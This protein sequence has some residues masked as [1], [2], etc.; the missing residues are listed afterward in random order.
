[1]IRPLV[2]SIETPIQPLSRKY[3][4]QLPI[5]KVSVNPTRIV[6][7]LGAVA[8]ALVAVSTAAQLADNLTGYSSVFIHKLV[9]LLNVD[10]ELNVPTFFSSFILLVSSMLLGVIS[11]LKRMQRAPYVVHWAVLSAGFLF[12]AF[13]ETVSVHERLIEPVRPLLG[14]G[15]LGIWYFAWVVPAILLVL[16]LSLVFLRFVMNLPVRIR[17]WFLIAAALYLGAAI[18]FELFEG[19]HVEV[20]GKENLVYLTLATIEEGAEMAGVIIFIRA[21]LDYIGDTWAALHIRFDQLSTR[22][23]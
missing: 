9:K 2:N 19:S 17:Q 13:D 23:R 8:A 18:G 20:Y 6:M 21:L 15:N 7:I 5:A 14:Q 12:M 22:D 1:M 11:V 10:L 16:A 4:A 3:A